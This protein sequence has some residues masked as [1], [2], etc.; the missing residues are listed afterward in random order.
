MSLA[1]AAR[2]V[3]AA[4]PAE[5]FTIT[6]SPPM[7]AIAVD[8]LRPANSKHTKFSGAAE[9]Q[10]TGSN[11][12]ALVTSLRVKKSKKLYAFRSMGSG[13]PKFKG[14]ITTSGEPASVQS[15]AL[16]VAPGKG[17][18]VKATVASG[19]TVM[20]LP[21]SPFIGEFTGSFSGA[22]VMGPFFLVIGANGAAAAWVRLNGSFDGGTS[23]SADFVTGA[24]TLSQLSTQLTGPLTFSVQLQASGSSVTGNGK[25]AVV[26]HK[27]TNRGRLRITGQGSIASG[28]VGA[29]L[30]TLDI[31]AG[32]DAPSSWPI[33]LAVAND[34]SAGGTTFDPD[35]NGF[36]F[37]GTVNLASGALALAVQAGKRRL[38]GITGSLMGNFVTPSLANGSFNL[39]N[40]DSG[41]V[42]FPKV[43]P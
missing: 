30:G 13:F 11:P 33:Q 24:V 9:L 22:G 36:S 5:V 16:T 40:G 37:Q 15:V 7:E 10:L 4:S 20:T 34:G 35:G 26:S 19:V 41:T 43:A 42:S 2:L 27:R 18:L 6:G 23:G 28:Y 17:E 21:G 14:T 12:L 25:F 38:G 31:T 32:P 3:D 8:T 1:L 29:Y 39:S